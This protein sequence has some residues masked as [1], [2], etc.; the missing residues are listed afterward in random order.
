MNETAI[1]SQKQHKTE[2]IY[3]IHATIRHHFPDLFDWMREIDDPRRKASE[4]ELAAHLTACLA[5]FLFKTG[6]RNEYNQKRENLQFQKN[7]KKLFGFPMP[8]GDSVHNVIQ[9]LNEFQL[10][11]LNQKLVQMLLRRKVFHKS[12][13][14]NHWFRIAIDGTGVVS[15]DHEH[16]PQCLHQ[17]STQGKTTY[18]HKVLDARLVTP[19]GFS[20]SIASEWIE[21]PEAYNK[22]DCERKA[23]TR[24]A[25]KLKKVYPR[26]PMIIL[27]DGL[28][29][30]EG[31]FAICKANQ[32]AYQLTFKQGNLQT[33]WNKVHEEQ[34]IHPDNHFS[35]RCHLSD[36]KVIDQYFSW[37]NAINYRGYP[38]NWLECRETTTVTENKEGV[39]EESGTTACFVHITDLPLNKKNSA[40]SSSTGRLR[41]KI[42]NEGFNTLK[43]GGYGLTHKWARTSYPA[44]KNYF[45]LMQ[46]GHLINQLMVKSIQYQKKFMQT[47]NHPTLQSLWDDLIAAMK[48]ANIK[49]KQLKK[50][51]STRSQFR[52][53]T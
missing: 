46:M 41:W 48:W 49:M 22:Q 43:N 36:K 53:V 50:I 25:A 31:F 45:Q 13:Y 39:S 40:N 26:L 27:A 24:L 47:K 1:K 34:L 30:Y 17:T 23:F 6:S 21:N 12:R 15:F 4:Y 52:F 11:Q 18:S 33:V 44:L 38:L 7:Y 5:M 9:L 16:C 10:E 14:R 32:W 2:L 3:Q 42:E 29:P 28:Y 19:N 37:V 35:E 20:V 8:H 51:A